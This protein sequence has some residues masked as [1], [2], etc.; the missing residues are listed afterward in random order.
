MLIKT[1]ERT[2]YAKY[3]VQ[4]LQYPSI[5]ICILQ[6]LLSKVMSLETWSCS[7]YN[8]ITFPLYFFGLP[9]PLIVSTI[10]NL[11]HFFIGAFANCLFIYL[12]H[13]HLSS[14]T[15][16]TIKTTPDLYRI[17]S[18]LILSHLVYPH[19]HLNIIS[20][21]CIFWTREFLTYQPSIRVSSV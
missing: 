3:H 17:T 18:F 5:L 20:A 7:M 21:T 8:I 2:T 12:N 11:L 14:L 4:G 6:T 9:L 13:L 1:Q 10:S 15:L 16:S 19:L